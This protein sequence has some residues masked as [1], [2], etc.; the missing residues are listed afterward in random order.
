MAFIQKK[1]GNLVYM[2][3]TNITET[4]AFTT[5]Y[6]GVSRGIYSSLNLGENR[7]DLPESVRK[8]YKI[9][10]DVLGT[11]SEH[12]VFSKQIHECTIRCV[13]QNDRHTLFSTVPYEADGL[14]TAEENLPIIIFTADC[15]PILLYDPIRRVIGAVHAGWRGTVGDIA[16]KAIS[17]MVSEFHCAPWDIR[18]A[19]GP[20][21]SKCCFETGPE[22][23]EA[24][25]SI[26]GVDTEKF[27]L[28]KGEKAMVDL[29]G[30]NSL[31][32]Q[33]AGVLAENIEIST[34]CTACQNEKY[35]SHRVTKGERGSQA[36]IIMLKG[37]RLSE[38]VCNK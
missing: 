1:K 38:A 23:P 14:V 25:Q 12:L 13:T 17:K 18:A 5:R 28:R 31:L 15:I 32:L 34:D 9:I 3:A 16:G 36:A 24:V 26:L 29:K 30:I 8:N 33:H 4:H 27:I 11:T 22:V 2:V 7:G 20:G 37:N 35:W 6:G 21:I 10:C 19:I